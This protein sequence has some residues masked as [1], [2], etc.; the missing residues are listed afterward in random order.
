MNSAN[1]HS[2]YLQVQNA[3]PLTTTNVHFHSIMMDTSI[4]HVLMQREMMCQ[5]VLDGVHLMLTRMVISKV[6]V[7]VNQSFVMTVS[8]NNSIFT[9]QFL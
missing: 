4:G 9:M 1:T 2:S 5:R 8:K 6:W 7:F 3:K